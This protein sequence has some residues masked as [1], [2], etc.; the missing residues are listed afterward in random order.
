MIN[1]LYLS[2]RG[3]AFTVNGVLGRWA[4]HVARLTDECV[5]I[6]IRGIIEG[7]DHLVDLEVEGGI[8]AVGLEH[9][10]GLGSCDCEQ[11]LMSGCHEHGV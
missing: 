7:S 1:N 9:G 2:L 8:S 6:L 10:C 4:E 5:P 3:L 11:G